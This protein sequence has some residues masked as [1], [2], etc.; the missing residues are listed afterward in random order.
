[1]KQRDNVETTTEDTSANTHEN[2]LADVLA[3]ALPFAR[4][5]AREAGALLREYQAGEFAIEFK[6]AVDLVTDADKAS[7]KLIAG[8]IRETFPTHRLIG[9]EGATASPAADNSPFGWAVDPLDGT[10]NFAHRYQHF[11]VSICLEH[12]GEPV[13]GV[14]YDPTRDELFEAVTGSGATLNGVP[15]HVS[16]MK[17][18]GQ[19]LLA[20][21]FSYDISAREES[22]ALWLAFNNATQGLRR[23]GSAALDMCWVAAGRLDGFFERPVNSYDVGA[24]VV[25]VREAGGVVSSLE[26]DDYDLYGT[27]VLA[28]NGI[29]HAPIRELIASTLATARAANA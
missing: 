23:D 17:I 9:E 16:T 11:A 4:E 28:S 19:S 27:E 21:G 15:L 20:T 26:H 29:L 1:M 10:T 13:L 12:L 2:D 6:G 25:I 18:L 24:G 3:K 14:V 8:R 5:L 22:S 7:E